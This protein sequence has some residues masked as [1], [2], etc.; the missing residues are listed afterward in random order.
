M[1]SGRTSDKNRG[2][3]SKRP[4][5]KVGKPSNTKTTPEKNLIG[6]GWQDQGKGLNQIGKASADGASRSQEDENLMV[7]VTLVKK[8]GKSGEEEDEGRGEEQ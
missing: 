3:R 6:V 8:K 4:T 2:K 5:N 7:H 1:N